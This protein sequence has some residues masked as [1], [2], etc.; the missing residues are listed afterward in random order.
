MAMVR[1]II[2]TTDS[3]DDGSV[4]GHAITADV[5]VDGE[6]HSFEFSADPALK[7]L[8]DQIVT[9]VHTD[10]LQQSQPKM[11]EIVDTQTAFNR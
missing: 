4:T 5:S 9:K 2:I 1:R 8:L 10:A 3:A 7:L 6:Q 11:Q